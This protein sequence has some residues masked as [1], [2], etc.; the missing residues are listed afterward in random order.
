MCNIRVQLKAGFDKL[1]ALRK[2]TGN[3]LSRLEKFMKT[4]TLTKIDKAIEVYWGTMAGYQSKAIAKREIFEQKEKKFQKRIQKI[5][6]VYG[7]GRLG[8]EI[9]EDVFQQMAKFVKEERELRY[10]IYDWGKELL[11]LRKNAMG[12]DYN[13]FVELEGILGE[14]KHFNDTVYQL[15]KKKFNFAERLKG[16]I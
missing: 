10:S 13:L 9:D 8:S 11:N 12:A 2:K 7:K 14:Y 3:E 1:F 4:T 5:S 16:N 6:K 15:Q